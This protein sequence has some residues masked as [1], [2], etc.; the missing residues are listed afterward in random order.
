MIG[1]GKQGK[2]LSV[3]GMLAALVAVCLAWLV[4]GC[5]PE[6][7]PPESQG[8]SGSAGSATGGSHSA[9]PALPGAELPSGGQTAPQPGQGS[10][11]EPSPPT[12]PPEPV[13]PQVQLSESMQASCV[14]RVGDVMPGGRL[15]DAT[16]KP[17]LIRDLFGTQLTVVCFFSAGDSPLV[18]LAAERLVADL[19]KHVALPLAAQ[20]VGVVGIE[21]GDSPEQL[22][23]VL[24]K[25]NPSFPLL[26]DQ[27]KAYFALV[28]K[29]ML[30]RV[31]LLDR[32]GRVLW[33]DL[34]FTELAGQVRKN[35]LQAI[36]VALADQTK[37]GPQANRPG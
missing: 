12:E 23:A 5:R 18:A 25:V 9:Q 24:Q 22:G 4:A 7:S 36:A 2:P 20:G 32:S 10:A 37:P 34:S 27:Q 28:A 16:G 8:A 6:G 26:L 1:Q 15:P 35:L 3:R 17:Q 11:S 21:V 13:I 30:P 29:E 31:Y 33:F 14:V 19:Q